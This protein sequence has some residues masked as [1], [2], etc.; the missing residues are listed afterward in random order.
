MPVKTKIC[1]V[2]R[3]EDARLALELGCDA[4]G[5]NFYPQSSRYLDPETAE[6]LAQKIPK[7]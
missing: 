7:S 5:Y 2:T 3:E 1:G 4:I 6:N